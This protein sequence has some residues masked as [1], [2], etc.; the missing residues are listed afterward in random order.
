MKLASEFAVFEWDNVMWSLVLLSAGI[1]VFYKSAAASRGKS[2][3]D[4]ESI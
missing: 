4:F 3:G 1:L 2:A